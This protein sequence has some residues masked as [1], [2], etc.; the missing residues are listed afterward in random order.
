MSALAREA[1]RL[2]SPQGAPLR[3]DPA[4]AEAAS[5]HARD[6][7]GDERR[8]N[9][10]RLDL[11]LRVEGL[12]DAQLLP[13]ASIGA[14]REAVRAE[15]LKFAESTVRARGMSH[16]GVAIVEKDGKTALAAI[17]ARRLVE[18]SPLPRKLQSD[19]L[20]VRGRTDPKYRLEAILT[21]PCDE[22]FVRCASDAR[23]VVHTLKNGVLTVPLHLS[24]GPGRYAFE[25]VVTEA[26]GPE[27]AALWTFDFGAV[28]KKSAPKR[29]DDLGALLDE[30]RDEKDLAPLE[31]DEALTKAARGHAEE[32]CATMIAAHV[33]EKTGDPSARAKAAGYPGRVLENV[34]IASSIHRAHQNLMKSPSHRRNILDPLA[35]KAGLAIIR[36][37]EAVCIVELFGL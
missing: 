2:G 33:S 29:S 20:V 12:A 23:T 15:L 8:A 19:R 34:A 32:T 13:F 24:G 10:D 25:L 3:I 5:R 35:A 14:T 4:L 17:F 18:L 9:R 21:G 7:L 30:A 1:A 16:L 28:E 36:K 6:L 11:A 26:R 22:S 27:V 31:L 37:P